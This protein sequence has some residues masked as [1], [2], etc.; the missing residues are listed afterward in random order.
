MG[1]A[2]A[3]RAT[4]PP[5]FSL[6]GRMRRVTCS[7]PATFSLL[8]GRKGGT[9]RRRLVGQATLGEAPEDFRRH[10]RQLRRLVQWKQPPAIRLR[11]QKAEPP[12]LPVYGPLL[13]RVPHCQSPV[14]LFLAS[15]VYIQPRFQQDFN[16]EQRSGKT[17]VLGT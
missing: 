15:L 10:F 9:G 13:V 4:V 17:A 12:P 6:R 2:G 7:P 3:T 14:Q 5:G 8:Q 1:E 11:R 16:H